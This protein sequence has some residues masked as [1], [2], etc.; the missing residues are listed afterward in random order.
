[1]EEPPSWH[2]CGNCNNTF[3]Q[4][5]HKPKLIPTEE[6]ERLI[7][8]GFGSC[9]CDGSFDT[10]C[11]SCTE[12]KR[13]QWIW[14]HRKKEAEAKGMKLSEHW[15]IHD[16]GLAYRDP[17]SRFD[18]D[19]NEKEPECTG[20]AAKWC[21][22]CGNCTCKDPEESL[23]DEDCPLHSPHSSHAGPPTQVS[24]T[25][26]VK[27]LQTN[28]G[29]LQGTLQALL[30][31]E[32]ARV[33]NPWEHHNA[34]GRYWVRLSHKRFNDAG[35]QEQYDSLQA[36]AVGWIDEEDG[37]NPFRWDVSKKG[38]P[39]EE[40]WAATLEDAQAIVDRKL[41]ENGWVLL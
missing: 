18:E 36:E 8:E 30:D 1:V 16:N 32:D 20:L 31:D 14:E 27:A 12:G 29:L 41:Q 6:E 13:M 23:S 25:R 39:D 35:D 24:P 40:G 33:L 21:P 37:D 2:T 3:L 38:Q 5:E 26:V 28:P 10:G 7:L 9:G 4:A 19:G 11:P 17:V 15:T 22:V 34:H